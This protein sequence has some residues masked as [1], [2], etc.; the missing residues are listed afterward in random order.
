[1][2]RRMLIAALVAAVLGNAMA[3]EAKPT[4]QSYEWKHAEG[5]TLSFAVDGKTLWT[6][7]YDK[8]EGK[9]YFH[10]VCL[11]DGTCLTWHRPPDHVWHRAIWFSWK[12]IDGL[13]YW[14]ENKQGLSQGRTEVE[15]L[16]VQKTEAGTTTLRMQ[17]SY[18]PPDKPTVLAEQRLITITAPDKQGRFRMDWV[19]AF[20]AQDKDVLL[21]RTPIQGEPGGK[22]WGGYAGLSYRS[23]KE[24]TGYQVLNSEGQENMAGHGRPMRWIDL[25][26][27]VGPEKKPAGVAFFC[28]PVTER[29]PTPG[30]II[31]Q[32]HFGYLSPALLFQKPYRLAAGKKFTLA[33][34]MLIHPG[35]GDKATLDKEYKAYSAIEY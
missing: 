29:L 32:G 8:A 4:Y 1:M 14:E 28:H 35:L 10:P 16:T 24:L 13:N 27:V 18:H 5:K 12:L 7:H 23:A 26:G 2:A 9:P 33:Y 6:L 21:D 3:G 17:I 25:S 34:R 22:G 30:Y 19:M 20:T 31:M 15:K 11:A